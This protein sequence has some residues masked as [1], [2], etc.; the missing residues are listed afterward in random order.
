MLKDKL[1][2]KLKEKKQMPSEYLDAKK[3]MLKELMRAMD[4]EIG[5]PIKK[6]KQVT[7]ASPSKE[8]VKEGLEKAKEMLES[9]EE[10]NSESP[11]HEMMESPEHEKME[12]DMGSSLK[13]IPEHDEEKEEPK[14][15]AAELELAS[16][17]E[18]QELVDCLSEEKIKKLK[19]MLEKKMS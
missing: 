12:H 15:E 10:E 17:D 2:E 14:D 5:E 9:S 7:V 8:G 19:E 11:E 1:M 6:M 18:L 13:E 4:E 16:D 3:N